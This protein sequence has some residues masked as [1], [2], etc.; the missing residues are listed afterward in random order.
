M[1]LINELAKMEVEFGF[2]KYPVAGA[3]EE[4]LLIR[5]GNPDGDLQF[6]YIEHDPNPGSV[7]IVIKEITP[8]Q[9]PNPIIIDTG[10][11]LDENSNYYLSIT[12]K[13]I[14]LDGS[15]YTRPPRNTTVK[16]TS[17]GGGG[18]E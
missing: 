8:S 13:L 5:V 10:R 16:V 17:G 14:Q 12:T 6:R 11:Q 3:E 18:I 9:T 15:T 7:V 1:S 2:R 4:N